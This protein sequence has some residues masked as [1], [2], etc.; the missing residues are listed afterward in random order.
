LTVLAG[1][2][3]VLRRRRNGNVSTKATDTARPATDD[4]PVPGTTRPFEIG[5]KY[6][7]SKK[8]VASR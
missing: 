8:A 2:G 3:L 1:I 4:V 5:G 6:V 7:D